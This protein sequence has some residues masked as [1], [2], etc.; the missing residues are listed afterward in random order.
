MT[1]NINQQKQKILFYFEKK[2]FKTA[3]KYILSILNKYEETLDILDMLAYSLLKQDKFEESI[4]IYLKLIRNYDKKDYLIYFN[5]GNCLG[6]L[7]H[8]EEAIKY[9]KTAYSLN[10][11]SFES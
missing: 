2:Q 3:E 8:R 5:L 11:Q 4:K 9:L 6:S 10:N 7:G 1:D